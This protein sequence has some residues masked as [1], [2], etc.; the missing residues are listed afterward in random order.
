MDEKKPSSAWDE[1]VEE[2]GVEAGPAALERRQP[3]PT[4]L[5]TVSRRSD[6]SKPPSVPKAKPGDWNALAGSLGLEVPPPATPAK[7]RDPDEEF[8]AAQVNKSEPVVELPE[9]R[10]DFDKAL[11][12]STFDSDLEDVSRLET[13]ISGEAARTAFD[14]LFAE[15]A[16]DWEL[17]TSAGNVLDTPLEFSQLTEEEVA[18][19]A[20]YDSDLA[21]EQPPADRPKRRRPRRRRRGRG[22]RGAEPET[23]KD[24]ERPSVAGEQSAEVERDD[25]ADVESAPG[26][27]PRRRRPRRRGRRSEGDDRG[28]REAK[29][30]AKEDSLVMEQGG[31]FDLDDDLDD[32]ININEKVNE[33][34][35]EDSDDDDSDE[36]GSARLRANH[37]NLPT[38]SEAIGGIVDSNMSQRSKSPSKASAPR[39]RG[40]GGGRG[41][42]KS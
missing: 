23:A 25:S 5:P 19:S 18:A 4:E 26:E 42:R 16:S 39:G 32:D 21:E 41:R 9:L 35:L 14:A 3:P 37:R 2:L 1:L 12:E 40:R 28:P 34:D 13:G 36:Q 30:L 17:P 15:S 11:V 8:E 33:G 27:K 31:E 22:G 6:P 10:S 7:R 38:W 24:A 29:P 20:D